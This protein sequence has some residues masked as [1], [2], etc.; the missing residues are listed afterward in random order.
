[1]V[2]D[3]STNTTVFT[4]FVRSE[5][6]IEKVIR[7]SLGAVFFTGIATWQTVTSQY[8]LSIC[9]YLH[10]LGIN[11]VTDTA[12]M[13]YLKSLGNRA[14]QKLISITVCSHAFSW[15]AAYRQLTIPVV[16]SGTNPK[17]ACLSCLYFLPKTFFYRY[18]SVMPRHNKTLQCIWK[19]MVLAK[20]LRLA[21]E[22]LGGL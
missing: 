17:P 22:G 21:P 5:E 7:M 10:M 4:H 15:M 8:I 2:P 13:V 18:S 1:M 14:Y 20:G 9:H 16:V 11:T 3:I 6:S 19:P 12:Q